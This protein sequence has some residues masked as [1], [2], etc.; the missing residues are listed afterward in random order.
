MKLLCE[1]AL[2]VARDVVSANRPL[3]DE[4]SAELRREERVEGAPLQR[5]LERTQVPPSLKSFVLHGDTPA[6]ARATLAAVGLAP[7]S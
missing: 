6:A 7:A 1:A 4:L 5:W 2:A 3:H